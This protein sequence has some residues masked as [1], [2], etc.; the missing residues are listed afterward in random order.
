MKK[1][2]LLTVGLAA[3]MTAGM[4]ITSLAGW[5]LHGADWYY[6]KDSNHEMVK[7]DWAQSGNFWYYLGYD[8]KMLTNTM[9]DDTYY[10]D[11][12]GAMT[13]GGWQWIYDEGDDEGAWRYFGSNGRVYVDGIK[14]IHGVYYHFDDTKM[15]TGWV[16][17]GEHTYYFKEDGSMA[18]GWRWLP[19]N[20]EDSWNEYWYYFSNAGKMTTSTEKT[21]GGVEYVF[22]GEGRMLTGWVD[23][24]SFTCSALD[25]LST[26]DIE[27][28]KYFDENGAAVDGWLQL[29]SPSDNE[30]N[31]YYFRKGQAYYAGHNKT[32]D[33]GG[34]GIAKID[35]EYYCFDDKGELVTGLIETSDGTMF[36]DTENGKMRTGR[37]TVYDDEYYGVVFCFKEKGSVGEGGRGTGVNGVEDGYLYE[38]GHPVC[39]EEGMKYKLVS[40][41]KGNQYIVNESGKI[42]TSGYATDADDTKWKITKKSDGTYE[43]KEV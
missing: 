32:T 24:N 16:E 1:K 37:V 39:A 5:E 13:V 15:S 9:V 29:D 42:K 33:F 28:L 21:I 19:E 4:A 22:D 34:Y 43:I 35:G 40:D 8:G 30:A 14:Q 7:D 6:Y 10:V 17:E 2:G 20:D 31:Y 26:T 27:E 25:N 38:D 36:F 12:N 11:Q 41:V 3:A 18:T 23:V